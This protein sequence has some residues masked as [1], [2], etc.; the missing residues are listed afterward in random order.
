MVGNFT[1]VAVVVTTLTCGGR[2]GGYL[3]GVLLRA[4]KVSGQST[5]ISRC[6][7]AAEEDGESKWKI[8][9]IIEN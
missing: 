1:A 8:R 9:K 2:G 6:G 3:G 5:A 7:P 4:I